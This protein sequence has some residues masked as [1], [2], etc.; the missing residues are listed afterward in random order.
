MNKMSIHKKV[1]KDS[2]KLEIVLGN[3]VSDKVIFVKEGDNKW[4]KYVKEAE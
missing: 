1:G 3:R 2:Y 4:V